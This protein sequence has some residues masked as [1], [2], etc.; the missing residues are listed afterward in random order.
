MKRF[1][2][3][4]YIVLGILACVGLAVI[5][6]GSAFGGVAQAFTLIRQEARDRGIGYGCLSGEGHRDEE[7]MRLYLEG[8]M[9]HNG[10][11]VIREQSYENREAADQ[12]EVRQI[13]VEANQCDLVIKETEKDTYGIA[14]DNISALQLFVEDGVLTVRANDDWS[15]EGSLTLYIPTSASVNETDLELGAGTLWAENMKTETF[16][17]QTGACL[18]T[19]QSLQAREARI[20]AGVGSAEIT[21]SE[22]TDLV[23]D[24]GMGRVLYGGVVQGDVEAACAIGTIQINVMGKEDDFNYETECEA[25]S[26]CIGPTEGMALTAAHTFDNR[27]EKKMDL[28]CA[29][30]EIAVEFYPGN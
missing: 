18:A 2:K 23:I 6:L 8:E 17:L 1:W 3:T 10:Y 24:V 14:A 28:Y 29:M 22:V 11:P 25:G 5:L 19:L 16:S 15:G 27:A 13:H 30:G 9:K 12:S 7:E 26:I 21:D 20:E 4:T